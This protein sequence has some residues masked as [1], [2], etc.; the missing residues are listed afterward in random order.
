[1][2]YPTYPGGYMYPN[3]T[4]IWLPIIV[5]YIVFI[6][7]ASGSAIMLSLGVLFDKSILRRMVP[8]FL[9]MSISTALVYL[10]GPL[11]DLRRPDRA[12]YI[13][14]YPHVVPSEM[15]PGISI[16]SFMAT[17]MWPLLIIL[18]FILGYLVLFR[19]MWNSIVSKILAILLIVIGLVWSTYFAPLLF[20]TLPLLAL[21]NF[22]PL[23]PAES[24]LEA[25]AL[26]SS[27][28]LL[29]LLIHYRSQEKSVAKFLSQVI[30]A[31]SLVFITLRLFQVFR[32]YAYLTGSPEALVFIEVFSNMNTIVLI[33]AAISSILAFYINIKGYNILTILL[34][35]ITLIWVFTDRWLFA[36]N[37]Q[38]ISKTALAVVPYS[39]DLASWVLESIAMAFLALFIYYVLYT[40]IVR[41]PLLKAVGEVK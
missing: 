35:L 33:L 25:I 41:E 19:G 4:L 36:I 34:A 16:I 6:S 20:T 22:I 23:L 10:L 32:L 40:W 29:A 12:P 7:I 27:L 30:L 39:L 11:A 24:F 21:Y 2:S 5:T 1:M 8:L 18:L 37:I 38:S 31:C 15:Y 14:L 28:A 17:I 26:S 13:F 9:M 3:E